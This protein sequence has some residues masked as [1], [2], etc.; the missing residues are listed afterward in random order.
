MQIKYSRRDFLKSIAKSTSYGLT[1]MS[2]GGLYSG[3]YNV[4]HAADNRKYKAL[5][6]VFLRGGNDS[7]NLLIPYSHEDYIKYRNV[8]KFLAFDKSNELEALQSADNNK[9]KFSNQNDKA[10]ALHPAM[11]KLTELFNQKEVSF[12]ANVG[13]LLPNNHKPLH[14]FAHNHQQVFWETL[15]NSGSHEAQK[16]WGARLWQKQGDIP[17][18]ISTHHMGRL[19]YGGN[20]V[21]LLPRKKNNK[22]QLF[23][24]S[25]ALRA[26]GFGKL[27][28]R[29]QVLEEMFDEYANAIVDDNIFHST[30]SKKL[31]N[32]MRQNSQFYE[33]MKV[34]A[35]E[36][37]D[38]FVMFGNDTNLENQFEAVARLIKLGVQKALPTLP[39]RQI[40]LINHT[41]Y[42]THTQQ[43]ERQ[44]K[45]LGEL[46]AALW[47]FSNALKAFDAWD[48]T[49]TFIAS[50]FGRTLTPNVDGTDHGWGGNYFA[51]GGAVQGGQILGKYPEITVGGDSIALKK[52]RVIPTTAIEH[53]LNPMLNWF[54]GVDYG[55]N[56][57]PNSKALYQISDRNKEVYK[58]LMKSA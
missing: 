17:N 20:K 27:N 28:T 53:F 16:G 21:G 11:P 38:S 46:D 30:Y 6:C 44:H 34:Q 33:L 23:R 5:V 39:K 57:F 3:L 49:T 25:Q 15:A 51:L 41:G 14:L 43:T 54:V 24:P 18:N 29:G 48:E 12:V 47:K 9:G 42:D 50:E 13:A 55:E 32:N 1:C 22:L 56:I 45:L 40:F 2:L 58:K 8:R 26:N 19:F 31:I 37:S 52:G 36:K 35:S 4:A 7:F 10:F